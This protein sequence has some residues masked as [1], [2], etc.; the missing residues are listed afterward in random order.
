MAKH[1]SD[2]EEYPR[3]E[4]FIQSRH[5]PARRS[6]R[7]SITLWLDWDIIEACGSQPA[8]VLREF[9]ETNF[10]KKL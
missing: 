8:T 10:W 5:D 3:I 6:R 7:R 2:N 4:D 9:I 1:K